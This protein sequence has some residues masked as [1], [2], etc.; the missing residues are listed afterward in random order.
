MPA[1]S[2]IRNFSIIA[3]IDHGK[4]T[5]ADQFLL[6]TGR[7]HRARVPRPDC[8]TTWTWSAS[9]ASPSRHAPGHRSTTS[10][11]GQTY[12]LNLIDTPGH[13][14]FHYE[15]SRSLAACEG[16]IL[17]V[18]AIQGVQAQTVANAYLAIER[19]P[20]DRPGAEQDRHADRP[21]RRG[22]RPRWS[23]AARASTPT[24]SCAS[25][26]RPAWASPSVLAADHRARPAPAGRPERPA[27]GP[28]LQLRSSTTTRA[29]S[30][31]SASMDGVAQGRPEDPADARRDR[32]RGHRAWA[33]SAPRMAPCDELGV[34]PGR[35]LHR[36]HQEPRRRPHRRHGHR[37][38]QPD[39]RRPLPGYKE[40]KPMVFCGLYPVNNNEFEDLREALGKLKLNDSS[41]TFEP[42]ISDGLGLR[43]PLRLPGHAPQR[44]HPAAARAR[45]QPGPGADGP[46]RHLRDPQPQGRDARHIDNP[47]DVPDAG[48]IE[49][50]REPIVQINF[51][52]PVREH[53]RH[54]AAVHDRRGHV[55][56][57][58]VPQPARGPSSSTSCRWRR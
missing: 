40:P 23:T 11:D 37:R 17:L 6:K 35:L 56:P 43:L 47:Q 41:F 26:A 54:H 15:V 50:F 7:D 46:E 45:E 39:G 8:S 32:A 24:R 1:P 57:D 58:R 3:H 25:A 44:D 2:L 55:R 30:S 13:V 16:A 38:R 19:R 20:D 48:Q 21:A 4:S 5:L 33:S 52:L 53:R 49:E 10:Y 22:H 9:A 29:S 34:G 42:E 51:L 31:T 12:E 27:Q 18:D 36:Q 14:D 28:D